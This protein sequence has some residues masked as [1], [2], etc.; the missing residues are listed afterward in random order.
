MI[1]SYA[2]GIV[3]YLITLFVYI[4]WLFFAIRSKKISKFPII[5]FCFIGMFVCNAL[6]SIFVIFP[7]MFGRLEYFYY[8]NEHNFFS[9]EYILMV[10][11][12]ALLFYLITG[13]YFLL[14]KK[15]TYKFIFYPRADRVF[16]YLLLLFMMSIIAMYF[17]NV[18]Y[19]PLIEMIVRGLSGIDIVHYRV[20]MTYGLG[21]YS[22][23][24]LGFSILPR[25]TAIYVFVMGLAKSKKVF[26]NYL[27]LVLCIIISTFTGGKG[28]VLGI[29]LVL[30]IAYIL[31]CAGYTPYGRKPVAY[32]KISVG[33]VLAFIP[34]FFM[35][36]KYYGDLSVFQIFV[37]ILHRIIGS[38]EL[39]AAAVIYTQRNGFF[40]GASFPTIRGLLDH[41]QINLSNEM[42][43]FLFGPG[44]G[45]PTSAL[46][47]GFLNFG[48]A[49]FIGMAICTF[50]III[51]VQDFVKYLPKDFLS[52]SLVVMYSFFAFAISYVSLSATFVSLTYVSLFALLIIV[53]YFLSLIISR[54]K[55]ISNAVML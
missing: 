49:G 22:L 11:L 12:Q 55:I 46:T 51:L 33:L 45:A 3:L 4:P 27:I 23:Y 29:V 47:E 19:P 50:I 26:S 15:P 41:E 1:V 5:S 36:I 2:E 6:G 42:H 38:T 39:I 16:V 24:N 10:N 31:F 9:Y 53:R 43:L 40:N 30:I 34:T 8:P 44:G 48:W 32:K 52:F 13:F 20:S 7:N 18:G 14:V 35:Y 37:K 54:K 17:R 25:L 21:D 28:G